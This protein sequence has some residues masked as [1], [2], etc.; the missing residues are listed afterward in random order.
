MYLSAV[1]TIHVYIYIYICQILFSFDVEAI[2]VTHIIRR[3]LSWQLY[4]SPRSPAIHWNKNCH[5]SDVTWASWPL[6]SPATW[7]FVER[8]VQASIREKNQSSASLSLWEGNAAV[9]DGFPLQKDNN[10][11]DDVHLQLNCCELM[12]CSVRD[13]KTPDYEWWTLR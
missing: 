10:V 8:I 2:L 4:I 13:C 1:M 7:L 6:K 12:V 9:T 5:Y 3:P 11:F